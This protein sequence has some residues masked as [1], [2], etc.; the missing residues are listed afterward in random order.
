MVRAEKSGEE[1]RRAGGVKR[2]LADRF[3]ELAYRYRAIRSRYQQTVHIRRFTNF[4][5]RK[6]SEICVS[7]LDI[8]ARGGLNAIPVFRPLKHLKNRLIHGIEP[9]TEEAK[10]LR[11]SGE[12]DHV[13]TDGVAWYDGEAVLHVPEGDPAS[14]S[15]RGVDHVVARHW[16]CN[17]G[18][19][20]CSQK[21]TEYPICVKKLSSILPKG[22]TY[23]FIKTDVEG[24]DYDVLASAEPALLEKALCV[25]CETQHVPIFVGQRTMSQ[26]D[27]FLRERHFLPYSV[28]LQHSFINYDV[29][30][31]RDPRTI[32]DLTTLLKYIC[33]ACL[34]RHRD[35]LISDVLDIYE[36]R[37]GKALDALRKIIF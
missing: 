15:I 2:F 23:D 10:R 18:D 27:I 16:F 5:N 21:S 7:L 30:Y 1:R 12:Y 14:A 26:L 22:A 34:L 35:S 20:Y 36:R 17:W 25:I 3:P 33:L 6:H 29:V 19:L 13:F 31:V 28:Q 11:K 37:N 9:D 24:C 4:L 32:S 8:G